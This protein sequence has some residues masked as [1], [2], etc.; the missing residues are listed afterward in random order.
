MNA[1]NQM[2]APSPPPSTIQSV[3]ALHK[4]LQEKFSVF[5]DNLPL[6]I[7]IDKQLIARIPEL[8]RKTLRNALGFHTNG[9]RYLKA[10]AKA[11]VRFDLDGNSAGEVMEI[12]RSHASTVLQERAKKEAELRKAQ[13]LAAE[14]QRKAAEAQREADLAASQRAEKL[15]QLAAKFSRSGG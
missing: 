13:R 14:V 1:T 2:N 5:R 11:T 7:G 15:N 12:H 3:R 4:E 10:M 9:L 6:A 8:D